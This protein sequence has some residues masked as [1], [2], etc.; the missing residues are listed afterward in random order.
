LNVAFPAP[1]T[2]TVYQLIARSSLLQVKAN[3]VPET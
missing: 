3:A 1:F 2:L